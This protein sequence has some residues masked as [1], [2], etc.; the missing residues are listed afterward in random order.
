MKILFLYG[1]VIN[2]ERGGVE[3]VTN[4]LAEAFAHR[5]NDALYLSL[6]PESAEKEISDRQFFLPDSIF[7]TER[8]KKFFLTF[9]KEKKIDV[10]INQGGLGR[11]SSSFAYLARECGIPVVSVLHSGLLDFVRNCDESFKTK[12]HK[13]GLGAFTPLL[14]TS[15]AK[16]ILTALFICRSRSHFR[17]LAR[18]SARIVLLSNGFKKDLAEFFPG[19][20]LPSIIRVIANPASFAKAGTSVF[21]SKKREILFVGRMNFTQKRPDLLLKI[22]IKLQNRFPAWSLRFVGDGEDMARMRSLAKSLNVDRVSFEGFQDP[23]PYYRDAS[24]FCMTSTSE[25]FGMVLVEAAA[26]GCVPVAFDS[27]AAVRD[28]IDDGENGCL[29]PAFDCEKYAE[30]LARLMSDDALRER[31]AKNALAQIPEKFSPEEIVMRWE[32]LF[33]EI[34]TA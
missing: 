27:F 10:V 31:L 1:G 11:E 9:L 25:G 32:S 4:I 19:K 7:G 29:V 2:P 24:I 3:R 12:L 17:E 5:G 14:K 33:E 30:T 16:K 18:N 15:V 23:K 13:L 21:E 22:W 6:R 28:I 26:F 20:K 34:L 8:N